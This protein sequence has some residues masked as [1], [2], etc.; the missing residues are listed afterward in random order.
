MAR[1]NRA[2]E[3]EAKRFDLFFHRANQI[4]ARSEWLGSVAVVSLVVG[5]AMAA[6]P[7]IAQ[8]QTFQTSSDIM[9]IPAFEQ[10]DQNG[11]DVISGLFR[12]KSTV[13]SAGDAKNPTAFS[14]IWTGRTWM[15]NLPSLGMDKDDSIFVNTDSGSDEFSFVGRR[16]GAP[17]I[18]DYNHIRPNVGSSLLCGLAS[19]V[20]GV[21]YVTVCT[22]T[23][24]NGALVNYST[25]SRSRIGS[26][27]QINELALFGNANLYPNRISYPDKGSIDIMLNSCIVIPGQG[28]N[29]IY[30]YSNGFEIRKTGSYNA[31][32]VVFQ[33]YNNASSPAALIRTLAIFT[34]NSTISSNTNTYLRPKNVTQTMN[35]DGRVWK[36]TFN[37]NGDMIKVERPSGVSVSMTYDGS[38]RVTSFTNNAGTWRYSY[39]SSTQSIL[40]NPD[41]STKTVNY[42]KKRGYATMVRDEIGRTTNYTYDSNGRVT[43]VSYPEGNSRSF[44]YDTRGNLIQAIANPK[45]GSGEAALITSAQYEPSCASSIT[46]NKPLKVIDPRGNATDFT[47]HPEFG[48]PTTI[49]QPGPV[50]GGVRPQTRNSYVGQR[51]FLNSDPALVNQ[52]AQLTPV[53]KES[54]F[55]QTQVSCAG[56]ADEVKTVYDYAVAPIPG[57]AANN[58]VPIGVKTQ[59]GDGTPLNS[60]AMTYDL[61]GNQLSEDGPLAGNGDTSRFSYNIYREQIAAIEPDPDAGGPMRA[62]ATRSTYNVDG[63]LTL[64]E[65]GSVSSETDTGLSTFAMVERTATAYDT[66]GRTSTVARAGTGATLAFTQMGYDLRSRPDCSATRMNSA[67]FPTIGAAGTLSGGSLLGL[68][69]CALGTTG[70]QGSDRIER[71]V[72]DTVNQVTALERAVGTPLYQTYARYGFSLNGK[73]VSITDANGNYAAMAY[74]GHDRQ[75]FWYFP[76]KTAP[77]ALNI[78]DYEQ[79]GYDA[80]G[81]RTSLRKRDD[82]VI[83]YAYDALNRV[84]VKVVPERAGLDPIHTRDVYYGYDN[85]GLQ[86][87]AR[88][89]STSGEGVA[90]TYDGL[91]RNTSSWVVQSNINKTLTYQY[92]ANGNRTRITHPDGQHFVYSYDPL[93]RFNVLFE[94]FSSGLL[95]RN[96]DELG[97]LVKTDRIPGHHTLYGYD[98]LSRLTSQTDNYIGTTGNITRG[99]GYNSASQITLH[100]VDNG[101]YGHTGAYNVNRAYSVNGL[102]QYTGAGPVVFGYDAN[103]NLTGDGAIAYAYDVEN[104]LIGLSGA[105]SA[106]LVYDTLGRL[107]E[108]TSGTSGTTR[109]LYDGDDLVNEYD[110]SGSLLSRYVHGPGSD[111]PLIWYEGSGLLNRRTYQSDHQG[112]ITGTA[113]SDGRIMPVIN[114]YDAYGIPGSSNS[115]RFGYTGQA[116]M[117]DLGMYYYK[118]RFYA[119]T[120]GRFM[121]TDPIGYEDQVNLYAYVGNDPANAI[122]RTGK[123]VVLVAHQVKVG[124]IRTGQYH[125]KVAILPNNQD[126]YRND[127]RFQTNNKGARAATLGAGPEKSSADRVQGKLV[128]NINRKTDISE[129]GFAVANINPAKGQTEDQLIEQLFRA[130]ANYKDNLNYSYPNPFKANFSGYNSNS[131]AVGLLNSLGAE[132]VPL[133]NQK[134]YPTP[135]AFNP[136]PQACFSVI[137]IGCQ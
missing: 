33:L 9:N 95:A 122:D 22:Y 133:P 44:S 41:G 1:M 125:L 21:T 79:Y 29:M 11:V 118:A 63:Q 73:T 67:D 136:L 119:P 86:L 28:C 51:N 137:Q 134:K 114:T 54:S 61:V 88:F 68:S 90:T 75:S 100:N 135:G 50:S 96:Y 2:T 32:D 97:R 108:I 53:L 106:T 37:G 91:G 128:S 66:L 42:I 120:L 39:P 126:A 83:T 16:S 113:S 74:D 6:V 7:M 109:F 82:S 130:D 110:G 78:S 36:Y 107:F 81:N 49:T 64:L 14:L 72:Y 124:G 34:F 87:Y 20:S 123:K 121:Q 59:L 4:V 93:S 31:K 84:T 129:S 127:I 52:T 19:V 17:S 77:G 23:S 94:G 13:L 58:V 24:R 26:N 76:S 35:D 12:T 55:C 30:R 132:S 71:K 102:N 111:D 103:G 101:A 80:G 99:F 104:R 98:G 38:H 69:A 45:P 8:A 46:C 65:N 43:L 18:A 3:Y 89:G 5:G 112:S 131:Y 60:M 56:T 57:S 25:L 105:K 15:A 62:T 40:T 27:N 10:V 47:Y 48:L 92:D 116:W 117:A 115:G 70:V 85:R